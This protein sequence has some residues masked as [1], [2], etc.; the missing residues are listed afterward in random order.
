[1]VVILFV[2]IAFFM[3]SYF[4][5]AELAKENFWQNGNLDPYAGMQLVF[6]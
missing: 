4:L 5:G 6:L 3:G 1:M 2:Q